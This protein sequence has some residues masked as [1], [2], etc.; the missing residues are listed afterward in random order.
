MLFNMIKVIRLRVG[1]NLGGNIN[2]AEIKISVKL[3]AP[4]FLKKI[5]FIFFWFA[6]L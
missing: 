4:F 2:T 5:Y 3:T 1:G 6:S